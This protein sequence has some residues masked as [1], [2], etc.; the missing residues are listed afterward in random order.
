[1][2]DAL[3]RSLH[4]RVSRGD[5]EAL[6]ELA[7]FLLRTLRR[8]L[9]RTYRAPVDL[10]SD[11]CEDAILEY[12]RRPHRFDSSRGVLLDRFLQHAASRN[13]LNL[14]AGE[15][16]RRYRETR[17]ADGLSRAK[18]PNAGWQAKPGFF[19][20]VLAL[21]DEGPERTA[22]AQWLHGERST[23]RLAATLG[24]AHCPALEQRR[25]VKRFK[26]RVINRVL[27]HFVRTERTK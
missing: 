17:Y 12:G 22:F 5:N 23:E 11:A 25:E 24:I 21:V 9:R 26:D 18:I 7:G 1:M 3:I 27:R 10:I 8:R 16:R 19:R 2:Q 15:Q 14:L 13:L 4:E 6:D 20:R